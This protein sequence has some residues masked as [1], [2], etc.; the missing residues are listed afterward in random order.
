MALRC[1][2]SSTA[3][4]KA[5]YSIDFIK[6]RLH[7]PELDAMH[8][9]LL[10]KLLENSARPRIGI[11]VSGCGKTTAQYALARKHFALYFECQGERVRQDDCVELKNKI[12]LLVARYKETA[13][14]GALV[15]E[16]EAEELFLTLIA[17]RLL[18]FLRFVE[19][20][21][22]G[23]TGVPKLSDKSLPAV[24]LNAQ[25]DGVSLT[26]RNVFV[27]LRDF[28]PGLVSMVKFLHQM[29]RLTVGQLCRHGF[30][31]SSDMTRAAM[32]LL[33]DEAHI[34]N[35]A[36]FGEFKTTTARSSHIARPRSR[37]QRE[38]RTFLAHA[39]YVT[40]MR[41]RGFNSF[42]TGT[43]LSVVD[44]ANMQSAAGLL[45]DVPKATDKIISPDH[46]IGTSTREDEPEWSFLHFEFPPVPDKAAVVQI[47]G[48][49]LRPDV[50]QELEMYSSNLLCLVGRGR[51]VATFLQILFK[52][53]SNSALHA[54]DCLETFV[55]SHSNPRGSLNI[56][57]LYDAWEN[58]FESAETMH[59][60]VK[61]RLL[62]LLAECVLYDGGVANRMSI[63][64]LLNQNPSDRG[65]EAIDAPASG[66]NQSEDRS[67]IFLELDLVDLALAA[68]QVE[69]DSGT[70]FKKYL[71]KMN[72]P[73]LVRAALVFATHSANK[74]KGSF[75]CNH[76]MRCL[77]RGR[78]YFDE[79]QAAGLHVEIFFA[80]VLQA[81]RRPGTCLRALVR[82]TMKRDGLTVTLPAWFYRDC[83]LMDEPGKR[84]ESVKHGVRMDPADAA[85]RFMDANA[86]FL[87]DDLCGPDLVYHIMVI[88]L[89]T[90][91]NASRT[92]ASDVCAKNL[93]VLVPETWY[94]AEQ[95]KA[96]KRV[97]NPAELHH[98]V[99]E[100]VRSW[101]D[102][103]VRL[104][105]ALPKHGK[106]DGA[107]VRV[108][109]V[110][111]ARQD[112]LVRVDVSNLPLMCDDAQPEIKE[113]LKELCDILVHRCTVKAQ[114]K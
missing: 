33:F 24:W 111:V 42:W 8:N 51:F 9:E 95:K 62:E 4:V 86:I 91:Q 64:K 7:S 92:V 37:R 43:A 19:I 84:A 56:M 90:T 27:E 28:R 31:T 6:H 36:A 73:L 79:P 82:D 76:A 26:S 101:E 74:D 61:E 99:Q 47:L 22:Q 77:T 17:A 30:L 18:T 13:P 114:S 50:V 39:I 89:K 67:N 96:N 78:I 21:E 107:A 112:V 88:A 29:E 60:S 70:S 80:L 75:I 100:Q 12:I 52:S 108:V 109:Q 41:V 94:T 3:A 32:L 81:M 48:R 20:V 53:K 57:S 66:M 35:T 68:V 83:T 65:K 103:I 16:Q 10:E 14:R 106:N 38:P 45:A 23:G 15:P 55:S 71:I 87:Y 54:V 25:L 63:S 110:G 113:W 11:G 97:G 69:R 102:G 104:D 2:A 85:S 93:R 98:Q 5:D 58:A 1:R 44:V 34:W 46:S 105:I 49:F 59:A 72:E 40:R